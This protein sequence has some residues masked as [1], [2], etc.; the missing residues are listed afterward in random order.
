MATLILIFRRNIGE[1]KTQPAG[2]KK[3]G[4]KGGKGGGNLPSVNKN[5]RW[6]LAREKIPASRL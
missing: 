3:R 6:P 5:G 4:G 2:K 1:K